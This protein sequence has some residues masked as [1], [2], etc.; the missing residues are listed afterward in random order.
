[1]LN[2][3]RFERFIVVILLLLPFPSPAQDLPE[4][5]ADSLRDAI[6]SA[7]GTDKAGLQLELARVITDSD[8]ELAREMVDSALIVANKAEDKSLEMISF[9]EMGKLY[10][11]FNNIDISQAFF[12]S[13]LFIAGEI[14]D[15]WYKSEILFRK[16]SNQHRQ[17]E[18]F[19]ALE[20]F[21]EAIKAGNL[22]DNY[23][24]IGAAYSMMGTIMRVNGLYDRAIE[25]IIKSR[26][27]YEKANFKD[28]SAWALYLLGRIYAD[29]N[30]EENARE[31][32]NEALD[33]YNE[34]YKIDG[35]GNGVAICYEQI[36]LLNIKAGEYQKARDNIEYVLEIHSESNSKYGISNAYKNL[37]R[38][39]YYTGNYVQAELHL[40]KALKIK[41]EISD[42]LSQPGIYEFIGLSQ[43]KQGNVE[44]GLNTMMKGLDIAI[45]NN[46]KNIQLHIYSKLADTYL[47]LNKPGKAISYLNKQIEIQDLSLSGA[48]N[49]KMEQLQSIY[50]IEEKN[51]QI[52]QLEKQNEINS[53]L[54]REQKIYQVIMII[55]IFTV[56]LIAII[57]YWFYSR[58]RQKNRVLN[59]INVSKDKLFSIIAHDL[60][61]PIGST[62]G[63]SELLTEESED[64][65]PEVIKN[66]A[67]LIHRSMNQTNNLLNNLLIWTRSQLNR[68][69]YSPVELK[70]AD[71]VSESIDSLSLQAENKL[72]DIETGIND[73]LRV[74]GDEEMLKI[75][76][77][78]LISNAI[79][80]SNP[81]NHV[82]VNAEEINSFI[83]ISVTDRGI[84]MKKDALAVLFNLES[85]N[86]KPGTSG[87][88]G[89]GLGLILVKDFVEKHGGKIRV[90]S[91][92]K[93]GSTFRFTVKKS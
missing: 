59:E 49:V 55:G 30:L 39:D 73:D 12:D 79:K 38:V 86:S 78:N 63:L 76:L 43:I 11:T 3:F 1:M 9:Y 68:I 56:I 51:S 88:K 57:I 34:L 65:D 89:T 84:G 25:Y 36:G 35:I 18:D 52:E 40:R 7:C 67:E 42:F 16:G 62:L 37:G 31:Y 4:M 32:F 46:Q 85:D 13:A 2:F 82:S 41:E 6:I 90:E 45:S 54:I 20:Y 75:I 26:L 93:K 61:G 10:T 70:L 44:E 92:E 5:R 47:D 60:K 71:I 83:E 28:G 48:A 50:E 17:T 33:I 8:R 74:K 66:H 21:N 72:I 80:F 81:G 69:E 53:L 91:E 87:E 15:N 24:I 23:R 14:E 77:R 22:S 64:M 58:L 19:Q 29:L 27:N